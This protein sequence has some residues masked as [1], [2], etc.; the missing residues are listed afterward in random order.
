MT[1]MVMAECIAIKSR[2]E[3]ALNEKRWD[4]LI[5]GFKVVK[6]PDESHY[7]KVEF[8]QVEV[9]PVWAEGCP[10]LS[11]LIS[12]AILGAADSRF[13]IPTLPHEDKKAGQEILA[14]PIPKRWEVLCVIHSIAKTMTRLEWCF[15]CPEIDAGIF[16]WNGKGGYYHEKA[17]AILLGAVRIDKHYHAGTRG[18][19]VASYSLINDTFIDT[20]CTE[21]HVK[22]PKGKITGDAH[23]AYSGDFIVE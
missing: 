9:A 2:I 14:L 15:I 5:D 20:N 22:M 23:Y 11:R 10:Y 12:R 17:M 19:E 21:R 1:S 13:Y 18:G 6:K 7:A 3:A 4:D 16:S 8:D